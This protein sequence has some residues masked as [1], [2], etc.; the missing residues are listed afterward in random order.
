MPGEFDQQRVDQQREPTY[1]AV[2]GR[3]LG[4]LARQVVFRLSRVLFLSCSHRH[5]AMHTASKKCTSVL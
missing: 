1:V 3:A 2:K 4:T 5:T